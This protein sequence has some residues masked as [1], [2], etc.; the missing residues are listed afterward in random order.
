MLKIKESECMNKPYTGF[1]NKEC[2]ALLF[3][4]CHCMRTAELIL[5]GILCPAALFLAKNILCVN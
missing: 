4:L 3:Q 2:L 1:R 5:A